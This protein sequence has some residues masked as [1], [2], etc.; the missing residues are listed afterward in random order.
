MKGGG[1]SEEKEQP[2]KTGGRAPSALF[3]GRPKIIPPAEELIVVTGETD[4]KIECDGET[5]ERC[6]RDDKFAYIVALARAVNALSFVHSAILHVGDADSPEATRE[7]IN[8]YLFASAILYEGIKLV[9]AMERTFLDDVEFQNGLRLT[10]RDKTARDIEQTHLNPARNH[11]VFHFLPHRFA[12][13]INKANPKTC[14]FIAARGETR[15]DI[16]YPFADIVAA[17]IL[18]GLSSD[19]EEFY[20]KLKEA[21]VSTRDLLVR[22]TNDAETFISHHLDRWGFEERR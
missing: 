21:M 3:V 18:V 12:G 20:P 14:I 5:F 9:K 4:W 1:D 22:F 15:R 7:R 2:A 10:L 8:S 16:H 19:R 6:R 11:A 13:A 17:E